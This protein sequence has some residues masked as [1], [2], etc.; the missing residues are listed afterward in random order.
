MFRRA[1]LVA[2]VLALAV[3]AYADKFLANAKKLGEFCGQN[4]EIGLITATDKL[5]GK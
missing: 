2:A 1:V 4:P 3:P 5:F